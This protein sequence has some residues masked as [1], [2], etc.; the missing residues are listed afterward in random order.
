MLAVQRVLVKLFKPCVLGWCCK[1]TCEL[2]QFWRQ[3]WCSVASSF[4]QINWPWVADFLLALCYIGFKGALF[5][6]FSFYAFS[7]F[8]SPN[9]FL[10]DNYPWILGKFCSSICWIF[11]LLGHS[12]ATNAFMA[13]HRLFKIGLVGVRVFGF[14]SFLYLSACHFSLVSNSI[15][16]QQT[17]LCCDLFRVR[18]CEAQLVLIIEPPVCK[19]MLFRSVEVL[20]FVGI[21]SFV[22]FYLEHCHQEQL[23]I[24][25]TN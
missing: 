16:M 14:L 11:S 5:K 2:A 18:R 10:F 21:H 23:Q 1:L 24:S 12:S 19:Q 15:D 6:S 8:V 4:C 7:H 9:F 25:N 20:F 17:K 13:S 3:N 22:S